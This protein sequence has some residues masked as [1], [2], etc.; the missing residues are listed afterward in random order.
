MHTLLEAKT[1]LIDAVVDGRPSSRPPRDV[2]AELSG[3]WAA[4]PPGSRIPTL[5]DLGDDGVRRLLGAAADRLRA[6]HAPTFDIDPVTDA[7]LRRA[8]DLLAASLGGPKRERYELGDPNLVTAVY[9]H[10][11]RN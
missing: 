1:A 2:L 11:S 7:A 3:C 6:E 10:T 4:S 5:E 8:I 9:F